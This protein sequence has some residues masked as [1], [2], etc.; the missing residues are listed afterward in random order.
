MLGA[1]A[2]AKITSVGR[3]SVFGEV[4]ETLTRPDEKVTNGRSSHQEKP[5]SC[6]SQSESCACSTEP[7]SC[8][9]GPEGCGGKTTAEDTT[10][11]ATTK[12]NPIRWL[13]RKR[14]NHLQETVDS[15]TISEP[16]IKLEQQGRSIN[17]WDAF[18]FA[19]IAG[20][21]IS[22]LAILALLLHFRFSV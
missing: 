12:L 11:S 20:I 1:S 16:N 19:L 7:Q 2:L 13:L 4:I 18:D 6:S 3:W 22:F 5:S 9:C 21:F 14:K 10:V 8:Y 17:N 15:S